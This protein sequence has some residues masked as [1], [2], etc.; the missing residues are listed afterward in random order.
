[1]PYRSS[2]KTEL[3]ISDGSSTQTLSDGN[4]LTVAGGTGVTS[5]VSATDTVTLAIGQ[6]VATDAT[7]QASTVTATAGN[8]AG[9]TI[10]VRSGDAA[11]YSKISLGTNANKA[12]VGVAGATDTFFTGTA[13]DDLVLRADDNNSKIHLGAGTSGPAAM[14][15]TEVANVGK[16]GIGLTTPKTHLTVEGAVTLK[17][18]AAAEADT[19]A[20]GQLWVKTAT[21]NEL[22][23]TTDAGDDIQITTGTG[24]AAA[25]GD[26]TG[27]TAGD[28]LTGGGTSGGVS[29]AVGAGNGIDVA[30]DAISV[31]VSDF[32][33]NGSDNRSVTATGADAM[34]AESALTFDGNTLTVTDLVTDTSAGTYT[35]LDIDFDKTGASSDTNTLIGLNV[36]MDSTEATGGS[37]TMIGAKLT[38][39]LS[40]TGGGPTNLTGIEIL[41]TG[42]ATGSVATTR[43]L[44]LQAT[45]GDYNQGILINTDDANGWD[46]KIVSSADV[47]DHCVISVG[48]AGA[49]SI[50]TT[51]NAAAAAHISLIPDGNVIIGSGAAV[52]QAVV[53]D[54]NAVDFRVG[55]D[56]GTDTLEIGKGSA[57]GTDAVIKIDSG[58]NL[59]TLQNSAPDDT[60]YSGTVAVFQAGEDLE[61]GEVVYLKSDGKVWKAVATAAA[62]SRAIAMCTVDVSANGY[63]AFL[64]EG[65]LRADTNFPSYSPGAILH[66]PEQETSGKNVPEEPAPDTAGDFVQRIGWVKDSN[67]VFVRFDHNVIGL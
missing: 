6:S 30:A 53:F 31:D 15:I 56:D 14:V 64:L 43:G 41:A 2:R 13:Q 12:T 55:L 61:I 51:D 52:D 48:A 27:V 21:P 5:T 39:T 50:T 35:A 10:A 34:N 4:T 37:N 24:L 38:P 45:G 59:V 17:E 20:Y 57:H 65:F 58:A 7:F 19:A 46:M 47:N 23:Y 54:G 1:M 62:T 42:A 29:L 3:T 28:G 32:M 36:D 25:A 66:T 26:I 22:Y 9:G 33:T 16:V 60:K 11:Q 44:T 8:E 18:Q 49:T 40:A 67:T 63:A